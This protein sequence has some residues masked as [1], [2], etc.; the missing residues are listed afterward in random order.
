VLYPAELPAQKIENRSGLAVLDVEGP[1]KAALSQD[2][3]R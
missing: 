1:A 3:P 2:P